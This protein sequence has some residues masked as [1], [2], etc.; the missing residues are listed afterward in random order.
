MKKLGEQ[1]ASD[2]RT[3]RIFA[4]SARRLRIGAFTCMG[5]GVF[6]TAEAAWAQPA[7]DQ[8][9]AGDD[10]IVVT[11]QKTRERLLEVPL[12]VTALKADSLVNNAQTRLENYFSKVPGLNLTN[13][14]QAGEPVV[15]IR[16]LTTGGNTAPTVGIVVD[17]VPYGATMNPDLAPHA[18]TIDPGDVAR[19]EVLRGP[20]GT[21][22][23]AAS[24]GGLIK[25]VTIDPSTDRVKGRIQAGFSSM[26][27]GGNG[28]SLRGSINIP[29]STVLAVRASGYTTETP[30]YVDNVTTGKS[31]INTQES[32]GGRIALLWAP[33]D[34][35]SVRLSALYQDNKRSG[36]SEVEPNLGGLFRVAQLPNGG[37]YRTRNEAYSAIVTGAVAGVDIVSTTG[38]SLARFRSDIDSTAFLGSIGRA[39]GFPFTAQIYQLDNDTEKFSQELRATV[40][41]G[42]RVRLLVGGFYTSERTG[43]DLRLLPATPVTGAIIGTG[44][45]LNAPTNYREIAGFS[46]LTVELSDR[47]DVQLGG[48]YALNRVASSSARSGPFQPILY[49]GAPFLPETNARDSVFTYSLSPRFRISHDLMVYGRVASGYR[50]GGPNLNAGAA[51]VIPRAFEPDTTV[52]YEIG[53][54]G[55]A[56]NGRFTFDASIYMIDWSNIQITLRNPTPSLPYNANIGKARSQGA[57]L[58]LT[59]KPWTGM[60]MSG[61]VAYNDAKLTRSISAINI[62]ARKGARLAYSSPW[63]GSVSLDQKIE[64]GGGLTGSVGGDVSFVGNR[65]GLFRAANVVRARFPSYTEF[66]LRAGLNYDDWAL[67]AY[68]NNLTDKRGVLRGGIDS[69]VA[70]RITYIEPRTYGLTLTK[71]F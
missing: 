31:N 58:T 68:V 44:L 54:K 51:A 39:A 13:L 50:P 9:V 35:F 67:R 23:G 4:S 56:W 8:A 12:S 53:A 2:L 25:Y 15:S 26:E 70:G 14:G 34:A 59:A 55:S 69:T 5:M 40:P 57:E 49:P 6:C 20:Q 10:V 11:A 61:W 19:I 45:I 22:Y 7:A 28:Y 1:Y 16:G 30:G 27:H 32:I 71:E 64:L 62:S 17:D 43:V 60:T 36:T 48:R 21:L 29:V 41:F 38:Y 42:E 3:R 24:L 46:A 18:P 37:R 47:F 63:S 33:S 65:T 52:N 66:S